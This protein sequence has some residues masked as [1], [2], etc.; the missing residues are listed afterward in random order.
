[1][2]KLFQKTQ[3][4]FE[5]GKVD[6]DDDRFRAET[7]GVDWAWVLLGVERNA[8][9]DDV[10]RAYRRLAQKYHPDIS[11]EEDA[12]EKMKRINQAF[13]LIKRVEGYK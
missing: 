2:E 3:Q 6:D 8:P 5:E 12:T 13:E 7:I 11:A 4:V 10:K 1:M 9:K